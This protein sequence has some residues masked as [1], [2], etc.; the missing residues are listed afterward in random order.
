MRFWRIE[1]LK[2]ELRQGP[3]RQPAAFA[4]VLATLL[5][6]T[7][8]TA[9]PG[10][11]NTESQP[12][13]ATNLNWATYIAMILFVSGGTYAA[14]GANGGSA[15][16]DFP[17]RYFAL[18][19]VL[20]IRLSVLGLMPAFLLLFWAMFAAA[21]KHGAGELSPAPIGWSVAAIVIGFEALYYWRLVHHFAEIAPAS[22]EPTVGRSLRG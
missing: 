20:F 21:F 3:L 11:W 10:V 18:T 8:T 6:Y 1:L 4:Y 2:D 13:P 19:W 5:L 7:I 22:P 12:D 17:A 16:L 14:Y 9:A 15:G